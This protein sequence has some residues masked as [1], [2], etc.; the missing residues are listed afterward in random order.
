MRTYFVKINNALIGYV[1][2]RSSGQAVS[3][4][5]DAL[6]SL[7]VVKTIVCGVCK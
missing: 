5:F 4:A 2:A 7:F 1:V 6:P 3:I